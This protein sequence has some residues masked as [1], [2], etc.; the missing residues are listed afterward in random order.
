[1]L[2]IDDGSHSDYS[3]AGDAGF[4]VMQA[5][6]LDRPGSVK[7]GPYSE[8]AY[9]GGGQF[10]VMSVEDDGGAWITVTLSGRD[11]TGREIVAYRF[12]VPAGPVAADAQ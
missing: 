6:A 12:T 3:A 5:A 1:M 9:P 2:A 10:G 11:W 4:P 8:G 7:G